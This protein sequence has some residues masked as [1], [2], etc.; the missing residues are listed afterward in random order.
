MLASLQSVSTGFTSMFI[1][2]TFLGIS[3]AAFGPGVPFYLSFFFR[4][5]ELAYRTGLF[6]SA[7]PLA[8]SF[9]STLAYGI[10][11]LGDNS[12]IQSWRLLFLVEGFPSVLIAVWAWYQ[13]PDS[14]GTARWLKGRERRVAV[15]RLRGEGDKQG[16][17]EQATTK[18][19]RP[20]NVK[21]GLKWKEIGKTLKDPK[22]YLTAAMFFSCNVA[23]S[24]MP[25]FSPVIIREYVLAECCVPFR[26]QLTA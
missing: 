14:P 25:V 9:A 6:I 17:H 18:S 19:G 2:R 15:L 20:Q 5:D 26:H 13:I 10:V 1:F 23:F 7:A 22:S 21:T 24:S 11:R 12:K 3:E 8:S 4:R 16:G